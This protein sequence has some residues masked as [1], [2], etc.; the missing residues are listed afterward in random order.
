MPSQIIVEKNV[1]VAMRDGVALA[2]DV[3]RPADADPLP[4]ILQRTPYD[5]EA[6]ALR[7]FSL[8]VMRAVQAGYVCVV[9]DTRGRF[10][11]EG[12]FDPFFDDAADG[13]DT[14]A[15]TAAQPWCSGEVGMAGA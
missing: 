2:T 6:A 7:N 8:E 9:Q 13:V 10:L 1:M 4:A 14:I 15:W 12:T 11:S 5:K 3:Y